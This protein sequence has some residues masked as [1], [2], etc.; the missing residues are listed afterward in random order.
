MATDFTDDQDEAPPV[1]CRHLLLCRSFDAS[2]NPD[3]GGDLL[4]LVITV[5]PEEGD[6]Q[7]F[8][9]RQLFAYAQLMGRPGTYSASL[10]LSYLTADGP[11]ELHT[12][13]PWEVEVTGLWPVDCFWFP[14]R[15]VPFPFTGEYVFQLYLDEFSDPLASE[16][17]WVAD[18][19]RE[20]P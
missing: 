1:V 5:R 4:R 9:A 14:M 11:T 18:E 10:R 15:R 17:V 19:E 2:D 12:F 8:T 7:P 3:F 6:P 20:L 16:L 13:G